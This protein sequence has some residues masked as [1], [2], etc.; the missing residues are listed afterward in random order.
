M[1]IL[2]CL[3]MLDTYIEHWYRIVTIM[4][5]STWCSEWLKPWLAADQRYLVVG[6]VSSCLVEKMIAVQ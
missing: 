4:Q 5:V 6:L 1:N 2:G 3:L